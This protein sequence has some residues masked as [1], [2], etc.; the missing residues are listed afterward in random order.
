[1]RVGHI[2]TVAGSGGTYSGYFGSFSGDGGPAIRAMMW[3]PTGVAPWR[4]G[5]V[6]LDSH[7]NRIRAVSG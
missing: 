1:M 5:F 4:H 7:N 3:S 6:L 2:Y